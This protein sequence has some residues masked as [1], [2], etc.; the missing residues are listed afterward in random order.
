MPMNERLRSLEKITEL[1]HDKL[2]V[3]RLA[4]DRRVT[5][6]VDLVTSEREEQ[7]RGLVL[8]RGPG[9]RDPEDRRWRLPMSVSPGQVVVFGRWVDVEEGPDPGD[10]AIISEQDVRFIE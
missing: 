1:L 7:G 9:R 6:L 4:P 3:R 5:L 10:L 8:M 2:L